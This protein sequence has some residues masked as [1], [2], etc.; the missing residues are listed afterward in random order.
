MPV[1]KLKYSP[2]N[3]TYTFCDMIF[4][5]ILTDSCEE[6]KNH[7]NCFQT[8]SD[9]DPFKEFLHFYK[10]LISEEINIDR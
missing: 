9:I 7:L 10:K 6:P 4:C 5:T 2:V 8:D 1:V 3:F